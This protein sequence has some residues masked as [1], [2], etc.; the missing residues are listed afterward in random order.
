MNTDPRVE[1]AASAL[2]AFDT[3]TPLDDVPGP[4]GRDMY[5]KATAML[6]A[7]D[8]ITQPRVFTG[9]EINTAGWTCGACE[10]GDYSKCDDCQSAADDVAQFVNR[11]TGA[12]DD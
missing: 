12:T 2:L 1:A 11:L 7:A 4:V 8:A 3:S 10:P 6:K 5:R 9:A